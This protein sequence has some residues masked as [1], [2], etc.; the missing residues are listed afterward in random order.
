MARMIPETLNQEILSDARKRAE[1]K[2]YRMLQNRLG[3]DWTVFYSTYWLGKTYES[4]DRPR[5]GEIDFIIAN[6]RYGILIAEV[7]GGNPIEFDG[8]NMAWYTNNREGRF[9]IKDPYIQAR[10]NKYA[11]ITFIKNWRGWAS[12]I[13]NVALHYAVIFPDVSRV[14]G[15]LPLHAKKEITITEDDFTNILKKITSAFE[16]NMGGQSVDE[17]KTRNLIND[18]IS[19]AAPS[20]II[21]RKLANQI[22]DEE[23]EFI[24]LTEQQYAILRAMQQV[25]RVS[26]SGCAGSGKTLLAKRKAQMSNDSGAKT[27]LCCFST[28]LGTDFNMYAS[29]N[30]GLTGCNFH[31]LMYSLLKNNFGL[32]QNEITKLLEDE[33]ALIET[34]LLKE[35]DQYDTIVIDEAQDF[36][37]IH[38]EI[39][40]LILKPA[41]CLYCFWDNN[42]KVL[43]P[44]FKLPANLIEFNLDTNFRNTGKIFQQLKPFYSDSKPIFNQGPEGKDVIICPPYQSTRSQDLKQKLTNEILNLIHNDGIKESNITVLTF[45]G[46]E[47]SQLQDFKIPGV[48]I[49]NFEN[50]TVDNTLRIETVRRF[51]GL[52]SQVVILTELDGEQAAIDEVLWN[53]LCYVGISRARNHLIILPSDVAA[54]RFGRSI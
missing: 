14:A 35:L 39:L 1:I 16:F 45:K 47:Q 37:N 8:A 32:R 19:N 25:P 27:L 33:N 3:N 11:L 13:G 29:E 43:R 12:G 46:K 34:L 40:D 30:P 51:K 31:T 26:V 23:E 7:K 22:V 52:E 41:G 54:D 20:T 44:D 50:L 17:Q 53:N 36:S 38:L 18:L 48:R 10:E 15:N 4:H 2:V 6:P 5:D 9:E 24:R 42:Q 28:L 21:S 49:S